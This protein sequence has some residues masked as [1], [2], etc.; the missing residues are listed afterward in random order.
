MISECD[1][2]SVG[3]FLVQLDFIDLADL[4][5]ELIGFVDDILFDFVELDIFLLSFLFRHFELMAS[6]IHPI[7][8]PLS[9]Q[10]KFITVVFLILL[11]SI[12]F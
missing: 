7:L 3:E 4:V 6:L 10:L 11:E 5:E 2:H 9:K 8:N 1:K 12:V